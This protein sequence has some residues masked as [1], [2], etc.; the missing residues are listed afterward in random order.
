MTGL[1]EVSRGDIE[2][3]SFAGRIEHS[4]KREVDRLPKETPYLYPDMGHTT[5][6]TIKP[7]VGQAARLAIRTEYF[8]T[9]MKLKHFRNWCV[10]F[11][12]LTS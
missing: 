6:C 4:T 3:H 9:E 12:F 8:T 10:F 5:R 11:H 1:C 2:C 7:Y